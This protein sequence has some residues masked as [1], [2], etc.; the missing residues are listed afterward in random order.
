M[1]LNFLYCSSNINLNIQ[2]DFIY[3]SQKIF[4][5]KNNNFTSIL[6]L[7]AKRLIHFKS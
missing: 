6:C 7:F 5:T 4:L 3:N 2:V 1:L